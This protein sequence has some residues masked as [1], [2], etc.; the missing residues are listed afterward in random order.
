M[1]FIL[2]IIKVESSTS[3]IGGNVNV[4][5]SNDSYLIWIKY[6][7]I[8]II[9]ATEIFLA[10]NKFSGLNFIAFVGSILTI[11]LGFISILE[12]PI[13]LQKY[14]KTHSTYTINWYNISSFEDVVN[15]ICIYFYSFAYHG[16]SLIIIKNFKDK[17]ENGINGVLKASV[18]S[19]FFIYY[20]IMIFGYLGTLEETS[21]IFINR[22]NSES[23]YLIMGKILYSIS[24]IFNIAFTYVLSKKFMQYCLT[25][26]NDKKLARNK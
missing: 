15:S 13:I 23:I 18:L 21:E 19:S 10:N 17:T 24:L 4:E 9:L 5:N 25:F 26:G 1:S 16:G 22:G 20:L 2:N 6:S 8:L 14:V 3:E 11:L 7:L 12:F